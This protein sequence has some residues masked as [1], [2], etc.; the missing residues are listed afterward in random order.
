MWQSA[1]AFGEM[2]FLTVLHNH[3]SVYYDW[4][5]IHKIRDNNVSEAVSDDCTMKNVATHFIDNT[6]FDCVQMVLGSIPDKFGSF[7]LI[8]PNCILQWI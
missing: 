5:Q 7:C 6:V 8:T 2:D 3:S 4:A 1:T